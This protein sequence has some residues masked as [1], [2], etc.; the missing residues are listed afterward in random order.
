MGARVVPGQRHALEGPEGEAEAGAARPAQPAADRDVDVRRLRR[1]AGVGHRQPARLLKVVVAGERQAQDA[2]Q[3]QPRVLEQEAHVAVEAPH[4]LV[5]LEL[6]AGV[7]QHDRRMSGGSDR[8]DPEVHVT[9]VAPVGDPDVEGRS[10]REARRDLVGARE[11]GDVEGPRLLGADVGE[12]GRAPWLVDLEIPQR[13]VVRRRGDTLAEEV[14]RALVG[15]LDREVLAADVEGHRQPDEI[16]RLMA[17]RR[18]VGGVRVAADVLADLQ[19][20]A[21][22]HHR[23]LGAAELGETRGVEGRSGAVVRHCDE[24]AAHAQAP[25][26]G[27]DGVERVPEDDVLDGLRRGLAR[28]ERDR[29]GHGERR[30]RAFLR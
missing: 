8:A 12:H 1:L 20:V 3:A 5:L 6:V 7:A 17:T 23:E 25:G 27:A 26:A 19:R 30:D 2:A 29:R 11:A 14:D 4:L 9:G 18:Q 16:R 22:A 15:Q 28:A 21:E 24:C 10:E 13:H